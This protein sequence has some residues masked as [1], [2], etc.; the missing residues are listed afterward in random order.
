[1]LSKISFT[2]LFAITFPLANKTSSLNISFATLTAFKNCVDSSSS[3]S[4][5]GLNSLIT[6]LKVLTLYI[7]SIFGKTPLSSASIP[8]TKS[9]SIYSH[10]ESTLEK[11]SCFKYFLPNAFQRRPKEQ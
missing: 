4:K 11:P 6:L 1:M 8:S 2:F 10:K 7:A 5:L 9:L 3:E